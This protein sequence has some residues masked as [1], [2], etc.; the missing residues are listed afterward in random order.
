MNTAIQMA[1]DDQLRVAGH[2]RGARGLVTVIVTRTNRVQHL[3]GVD[4]AHFNVPRFVDGHQP[5]A[6][7][8]DT[9]V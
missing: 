6:N 5:I 3:A 4:E 7:N 1:S 9:L 2:W 8:R